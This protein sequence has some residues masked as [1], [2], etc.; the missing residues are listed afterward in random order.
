MEREGRGGEGD[1][2]DDGAAAKRR[3]R[4]DGKK[5]RQ[6]VNSERWITDGGRRYVKDQRCVFVRFGGKVVATRQT[7]PSSWLSADKL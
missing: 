2:D 6:P 3:S 1:G 7:R 4:G 5:M